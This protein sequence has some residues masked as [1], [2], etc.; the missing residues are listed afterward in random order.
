MVQIK[1]YVDDLM[2]RYRD[3]GCMSILASMLLELSMSK[4]S[5]EL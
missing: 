4:G 3:L 2:L 5:N 1:I